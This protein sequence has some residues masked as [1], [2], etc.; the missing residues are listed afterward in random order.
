MMTLEH[1]PL[2]KIPFRCINVKNKTC[3]IKV[4]GKWYL[5]SDECRDS[6]IDFAKSRLS[7]HYMMMVLDA[8]EGKEKEVAKLDEKIEKYEKLNEKMEGET[9]DKKLELMEQ[10]EGYGSFHL[11]SKKSA[12]RTM[13]EHLC[14]ITVNA[15]RFP[16]VNKTSMETLQKEV[17]KYIK[18]DMRNIEAEDLPMYYPEVVESATEP[19]AEPVVLH[20]PIRIPEPVVESPTMSFSNFIIE[21]YRKRNSFQKLTGDRVER[22]VKSRILAAFGMGGFNPTTPKYFE[23]S[24]SKEELV[25]KMEL[26]NTIKEVSN[27]LE[28]DEPIM[29]KGWAIIKKI[30]ELTVENTY[31]ENT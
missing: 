10:F 1:T 15:T 22:F 4:K 7:E 3:V 21:E 25:K 26:F 14:E 20:T 2:E 5:A 23:T 28:N 9:E 24:Y 17:L 12:A 27:I 13:V 29:F 8:T 18:I 16:N 6:F 31:V 19:V 11:A 30:E